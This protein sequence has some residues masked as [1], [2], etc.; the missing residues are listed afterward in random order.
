MLSSVPSLFHS[1]IFHC[2]ICHKAKQARLSFPISTTV[3]SQPFKLVYFDVWGPYRHKTYD[4]C[5][6]F[7]TIV[8]DYTKCT[9]VYLLS[10]KA[11]VFSFFK[12]FI[13]YIHNHFHASIKHLRSDNGIEFF[14]GAFTS[15]FHT[16]GITHESSCVHTPQ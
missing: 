3:T 11:Q 8:D 15:L 4:S 9:W 13:A 14:H 1:N 16:I 10:S 2:V 5:V 12:N 7:L 6:S